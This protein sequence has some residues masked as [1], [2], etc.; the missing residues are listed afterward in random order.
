MITTRFALLQVSVP[1]LSKTKLSMPAMASSVFALRKKNP[2][3][4]S[5]RETLPVEPL[6]LQVPAHKD[7]Q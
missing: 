2:I 5:I 1:V 3:L 4:P 7:K 6:A